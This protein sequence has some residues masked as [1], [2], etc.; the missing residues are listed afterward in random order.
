MNPKAALI[1]AGAIV[2]GLVVSHWAAYQHGISTEN[3]D[4]RAEVAELVREQNQR[5][6]EL[7]DKHTTALANELQRRLDEQAQHQAEMAALDAKFTKEMEDEKRRAA[8]DVAA[9]RAGTVRVRDRFT[10]PGATST[11]GA[12]TAAGRTPSMGDATQAGGLQAADAEFLL[13]EAERA[14]AVTLQLQACQAIVR[15]DRDAP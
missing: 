7:N 2:A 1:L 9:L 4:R 5:L 11:S 8:A 14:D 6:G 15:R 13:R 10:C 3:A 12:G